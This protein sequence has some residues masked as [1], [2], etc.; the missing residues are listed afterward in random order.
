MAILRKK[1]SNAP[2][3]AIAL[4]L[5][6]LLLVGCGGQSAVTTSLQP[7][8]DPVSPDVQ[9]DP[10][11]TQ[12]QGPTELPPPDPSYSAE[13]YRIISKA[14]YVDKTTAGFLSQLVGC[15]SGHEFAKG[16]DGKCAIGLPDERFK[17]LE[18]LYGADPKADKHIKNIKSELWEVWFDDD[19]SV[20]VVNQYILADMYKQK[21]TTC[22]KMI[23]DGWINYDIW[24]M[25]GGQRQAGAYGVISRRNY[26][27]QFA[28]NTEYD[29]WY[30]YLS[31][32]YI[33]T[34]T[35]GMNAAG[36]PET[37]RDLAEIFSQVTGD[38]DNV[39]WA[40][41]FSVMISRAYFESDIETL[42]RTSADSVFPAG[43][44]PRE[45]ISQV[46]EVYE[47]YPDDWRAAYREYESK[48]Y[49]AGDTTQTDTDINCGFVILDLLYGGGDY[50]QTCKIGS[51]AGYDCETTV[52]IALTIL[53]IMGGTEILP[54]QTNEKIWQDGKGILVNQVCPAHKKDQGVWMIAEGL[55]DR[56]EIT[57]VIDKYV[58]NFESVL[59]EQGGATDG[60]YYYIPMQSLSSYDAHEINNGDFETGDLSGFTVRGKVEAITVAVTGR[61]A[62]KLTNNGSLSTK[63][64]GLTAG[65]KYAFTAFV[66]TSD[67]SSAFLYARGADGSVSAS[68][69][70]T[71]GTPKYEAQSNVKRTLVFTATSSEMEIGISFVGAGEE[72]AVADSL[73]LVRLSETE[74]GS[75]EIVNA[76]ADSSYT[77]KLEIKLNCKEAGEHYL[78]LTFANSTDKIV[79]LPLTVNGKKYASVALYKTA[80]AQGMQSA[81]CL[82]I[83]IYL[84]EGENTLSSIFAPTLYVY[85]AELVD[86]TARVN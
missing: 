19:F 8:G 3:R 12:P 43:S 49:L 29:N 7:S 73:K 35:L 14:E 13:Q 32:A 86:V 69:R 9:T 22:Q 38:R 63:V 57:T 51:L 15:L 27:P 4:L 33:A 75:A 64:T 59:L 45:V 23:T 48:H 56:I 83:P 37:A 10:A 31:E 1:N 24:D 78:K 52:G 18:G 74:A 47:K 34:D 55:P 65:E 84:D 28:G 82:Y 2:L 68:V 50:M 71:K 40:Q 21:N 25:G 17:Y 41:M 72:F 60:Y 61:Y 36:M 67:A 54:E 81:D 79:D 30:S 62:A 26:L 5:A 42:I 39:L 46:F 70:E 85:S 11:D 66:R 76:S 58:A 6:A 20:D 53:G 77:G 44:W 16:T 80:S